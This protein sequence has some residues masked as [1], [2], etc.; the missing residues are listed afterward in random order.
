MTLKY[1]EESMRAGARQTA[2]SKILALDTRTLQRWRAIDGGEDCRHGPNSVPMNKL[3]DGE[4]NGFLQT[5]NSPEFRDLSPKQIVPTLASRSV[6]VAS[7]STLYRILRELGKPVLPDAPLQIKHIAFARLMGR[8]IKKYSTAEPTN[9]PEW[10]TVI[11][12]NDHRMSR[13]PFTTGRLAN[14]SSS[15]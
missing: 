5:A 10:I 13:S 6:Y 3:S 1:L 4:R 15:R 7:E 8:F 2:A 11:V 14:V 12:G 9:T